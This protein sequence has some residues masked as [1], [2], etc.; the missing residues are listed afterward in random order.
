VSEGKI[1]DKGGSKQKKSRAR[2]EEWIDAGK[3]SKDVGL[4]EREGGGKVA[5]E[6]GKK[7]WGKA[8]FL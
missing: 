8:L 3:G 5:E 2:N 6:V 1:G 7:K 4:R